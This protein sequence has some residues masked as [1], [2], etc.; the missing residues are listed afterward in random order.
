MGLRILVD[1]QLG[2]GRRRDVQRRI[3][4]QR[5]DRGQGRQLLLIKIEV[6]AEIIERRGDLAFD[7]LNRF[8]AY[9][10]AVKLALGVEAGPI[11]VLKHKLFEGAGSRHNR[12]QSLATIVE[13]HLFLARR[14]VAWFAYRHP[15][16]Q[17][18][19]SIA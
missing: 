4:G 14:A 1:H 19:Y 7:R 11:D 6:D 2:V 17:P 12:I 15:Y 3:P 8:R 16:D 10:E 5:C 18:C 9:N 13:V